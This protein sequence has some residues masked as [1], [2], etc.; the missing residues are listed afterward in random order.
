M[1]AQ[2]LDML[3]AEQCRVVTPAKFDALVRNFGSDIEVELGHL[4]GV[5]QCVELNPRQRQIL[6]LGGIHHKHDLKQRRMGGTAQHFA[7]FNQLLEPNI[8]MGL[9]IKID[10]ADMPQVIAQS[11]MT[12]INPEHQG[13][14]KETD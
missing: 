3:L 10:T 7:M 8:L 1:P 2:I 11:R 14:D 6:L 4:G 12:G 13:V 5:V 9:C